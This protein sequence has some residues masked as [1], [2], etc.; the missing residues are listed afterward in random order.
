[1]DERER[2]EGGLE[3][4]AFQGRYSSWGEDVGYMGAGSSREDLAFQGP[5][6][7]LVDWKGKPPSSSTRNDDL[8]FM[9]RGSEV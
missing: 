7:G 2:I 8:D 3:E 9:G 4:G 5:E 6:T 1:M